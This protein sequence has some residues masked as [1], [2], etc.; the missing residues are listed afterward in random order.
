MVATGA[1]AMV[2]ILVS[3]ALVVL[4]TL[5]HRTSATISSSIESVRLVEEAEVNLLLHGQASDPL[6]RAELERD[7][8]GNLFDARAYVTTP[9]DAQLLRDAER[10]VEKYLAK[11]PLPERLTHET[12]A[13]AALEAL[14]TGNVA[15]SRAAQRR[16][17]RWSMMGSVIGIATGAAVLL[18]A[19][20]LVLWFRRRAFR[21]L[22]ALAATMERYAHG[23]RGVRAAVDGPAELRDMSERFNAM[24]TTIAAQRQAQIAFLGGV[25]HD[26]RTP[27]S[28]L[29]LAVGA[30]AP[31]EP[32][33]PEPRLRRTLEMIERQIG[34]MDRLVGDFL[35]MAK[36]EADELE[37]TFET[38]DLRALVHDAVDLFDDARARFRIAVPDEDVLVECD[39]LRIGQVITNLLSNALKYSP[40]DTPVE[41]ALAVRDHEASVA[42]TDHGVGIRSE[43]QQRIF[44]PYRRVAA[45]KDVPGVGLGL[46]MV[47]RIVEVHHGRVEVD[48]APAKGSTFRVYLPLRRA[49]PAVATR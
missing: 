12:A 22:L 13:Y 3:G 7:L 6:M 15:E 11:G 33:P 21:P 37:V 4:T 29:K 2:A 30:I 42:I 34:R 20:G 41:I 45:T 17:D 19:A 8:R 43:D 9:S 28:T 44:E 35:D 48:S 36:I 5:L 49:T 14:V 26:I 27:L 24:A 23:E 32:L 40:P 10:C 31:T 46:Y 39:P 38:R 18:L 47:H 16:A 1:I 25:A